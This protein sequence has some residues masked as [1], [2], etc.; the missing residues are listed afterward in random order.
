MTSVHGA[1]S[2][3]CGSRAVGRVAAL[4]RYPVKSMAGEALAVADVS[5]HGLAGDRRWAFIREGQERSGFP[6]LTIR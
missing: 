2:H 1:P 6:W 4:W 5:W 3:S